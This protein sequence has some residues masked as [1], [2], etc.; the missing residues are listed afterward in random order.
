MPRTSVAMILTLQDN[1]VCVF[2]K[3][4]FQPPESSDG[5]ELVENVNTLLCLLDK[6][7][8][9]WIWPQKQGLTLSCT[10]KTRSHC[11]MNDLCK[12]SM[13]R[14][15]IGTNETNWKTNKNSIT[16]I[17]TFPFIVFLFL[18]H[19]R[20]NSWFYFLNESCRPRNHL[21]KY[22]GTLSF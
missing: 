2:E 3:E 1:K 12:M 13:M 20:R 11:M 10:M 22:A 18:N 8:T 7:S 21:N 15:E 4:R 19:N 6:F 14:N 16:D 17:H 5:G 9:T